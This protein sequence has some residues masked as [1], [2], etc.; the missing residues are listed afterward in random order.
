[1]DIIFFRNVLIYFDL[2][3]RKQIFQKLS[4]FMEKDT[5]LVLGGSE[6]PLYTCN[7]FQ[8]ELFEKHAYYQLK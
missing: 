8:T 6:S 2:E 5:Y 3:K 1:M 7:I 4:T